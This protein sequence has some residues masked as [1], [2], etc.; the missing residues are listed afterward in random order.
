MGR[1]LVHDRPRDLPTGAVDNGWLPTNSAHWKKLNR[2]PDGE[3]GGWG[4]ITREM[5]ESEAFIAL[6]PSALRV[7]M[8]L[9][10][11]HM[12]D[13]GQE[14]GRLPCTYDDFQ[15]YGV[16]RSSIKR[17]IMLVVALG[18]ADIE[19][20]GRAGH[21]VGRAPTTFRLTWLPVRDG[22]RAT[23]RWKAV[24]SREQ[25]EAIVN[26]IEGERKGRRADALP[27]QDIDSSPE[28]ATEISSAIPGG[29]RE[30]SRESGTGF[31]FEN[32]T[33]ENEFPTPAST[34]LTRRSAA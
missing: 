29:T 24:K 31:S 26:R 27:T 5:L 15:R 4:W 10:I 6:S 21:G 19:I 2:A 22:S 14:N 25:A 32:V 17:A 30:F 13:G 33:R 20:E 8:R 7:L 23:N 11:E 12:A 18:F 3:E 16:R 9:W 1:S 28:G 34:P